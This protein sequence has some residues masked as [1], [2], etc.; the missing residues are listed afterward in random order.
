MN[1]VQ[2]PKL[3]YSRDEAAAATGYS[4][5]TI[6]RACDAGD[7]RESHPLIKGRP[8]AKGVITHDELTR[9]IGASK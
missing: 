3:A 7:L 9:W 1:T 2:K 4:P 5:A 8:A 6:K